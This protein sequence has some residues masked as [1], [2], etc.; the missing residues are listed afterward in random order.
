[1]S[2]DLRPRRP[3]PL[4][5]KEPPLHLSELSLVKSLVFFAMFPVSTA[6]PPARRQYCGGTVPT[7]AM[8]GTLR[9]VST[10]TGIRVGAARS[11]LQN[12]STAELNSCACRRTRACPRFP[13]ECSSRRVRDFARAMGSVLRSAESSRRLVAHVWK[14]RIRIVGARQPVDVRPV[15]PCPGKSW[16]PRP[17]GCGSLVSGRAARGGSRIG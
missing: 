6:R 14:T 16:Y 7:P 4:S 3:R 13:H 8:C 2:Y 10:R 11:G 1:M 17:Y 15:P 12:W 9:R 5:Q